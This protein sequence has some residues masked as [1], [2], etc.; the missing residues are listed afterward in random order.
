MRYQEFYTTDEIA[1]AF[2]ALECIQIMVENNCLDNKVPVDQ[3][4]KDCKWCKIYRIAHV[5][6]SPSCRD[7][8]LS[9]EEQLV[10]LHKDMSEVG[11]VSGN[12]NEGL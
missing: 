4:D 9:W 2:K 8:H 5:G 7:M 12:K 6:T 10:S 1:L 3:H 11:L